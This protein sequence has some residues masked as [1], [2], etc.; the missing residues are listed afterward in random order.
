MGLRFRRTVELAPGVRLNLSRSGLGLSMGVSGASIDIGP[1]S[2]DAPAATFVLD[3]DGTAQFVDETGT[4][5]PPAVVKQLREAHGE[6]L[7]GWLAERCEEWNRLGAAVMNL[8]HETPA[9][10]IQLAFTARPFD[11]PPPEPFVPREPTFTERSWPP[12]RKKLDLENATGQQAYEVAV[13]EWRRRRS[14]HEAAELQRRKALDIGRYGDRLVMESFLADHLAGLPWPAETTI[15]F[16]I[17]LDSTAIFLDVGLPGIESIPA[18]EAV[19]AARGLRLRFKDLSD[20]QVRRAYAWHI[21]GVLFRLIGEVFAALPGVQRIIA[22]GCGERPGSKAGAGPAD[23]LIS[24]EVERA[25]WSRIDF[26]Q[27][28]ALDLPTAFERFGLRR[29]MTKHGVFTAIEPFGA[30]PVGG[31]FD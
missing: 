21:H 9:P 25:N 28:D 19:L 1:S 12:A 30:V 2:A 20:A 5:H 29:K 23:Y 6:E 15:A 8:H 11:D 10:D 18:R 16:E 24:A 7:R 31:L 22:S 4:P 13:W 14:A 27:L 26:S 17:S 3:A